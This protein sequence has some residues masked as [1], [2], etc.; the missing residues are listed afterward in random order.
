MPSRTARSE[1][2]GNDFSTNKN[3]VLNHNTEVPEEDTLV[4]MD[5][6]NDLDVE[7]NQISLP[8][9]CHL[10]I[11]FLLVPASPSL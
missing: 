10:S 6:L 7:L 11:D 3:E 5:Y 1:R 8:L 9:F 2:Y 4:K